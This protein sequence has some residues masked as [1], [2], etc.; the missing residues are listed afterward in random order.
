MSPDLEEQIVKN[1]I[2]KHVAAAAD[3]DAAQ[4]VTVTSDDADSSSHLASVF[5]TTTTTSACSSARS[6]GGAGDGNENGNEEGDDGT[7]SRRRQEEVVCVYELVNVVLHHGVKASG[8]HYSSLCKDAAG[9]WRQLND[10]KVSDI[11]E[12]IALSAVESVYILMYCKKQEIL[13]EIAEDE[14]KEWVR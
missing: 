12:D 1:C 8:G 10:A 2:Q 11:D 13:R 4:V 5:P 3:A 9:Q 14:D 6:C 7:P